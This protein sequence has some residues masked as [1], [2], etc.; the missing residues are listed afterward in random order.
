MSYLLPQ[1]EL[2]YLALNR[3]SFEVAGINEQEA[4]QAIQQAIP[5]AVASLAAHRA[6][7]EQRHS[8]GGREQPHCLARLQASP[9]TAQQPNTATNPNPPPALLLQLP[10]PGQSTS[11]GS[12][13]GR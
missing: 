13:R 1:Q 6:A 12:A 7:G 8:R 5:A 9:N 2:P 3:P 10:L 11:T 4:E